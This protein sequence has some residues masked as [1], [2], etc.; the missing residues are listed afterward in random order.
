MTKTKLG[1]SKQ[2]ASDATSLSK[3]T[4]DYL[5]QR[6]QIKARKIGRRVVIPGSELV[7][8]IEKGITRAIQEIT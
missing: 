2:E 3:R 4:L 1:Y 7:R 6:G 8:I 5:I